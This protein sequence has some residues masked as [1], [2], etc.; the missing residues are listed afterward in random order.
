[1]REDCVFLLEGHQHELEKV[2]VKQQDFQRR[3]KILH[4]CLKSSLL[5]LQLS[6]AR[7]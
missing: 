6:L 2:Q 5:D 4:P 1:M 3:V 7:M